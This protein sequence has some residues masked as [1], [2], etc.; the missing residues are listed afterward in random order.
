VSVNNCN[1]TSTILSKVDK[2]L[3]GVACP[4]NNNFII[5]SYIDYLGC[6]DVSII[7]CEKDS[8]PCVNDPVI[9]NCNMNVTGISFTQINDGTSDIIFH[10]ALGDIYGAKL[11]LSYLWTYDQNKFDLVGN[12]TDVAISL[13]LKPGKLLTSLTVPISVAITDADGCHD[14]KQCFYTPNGMKCNSSFVPCYSS[15]N[16]LVNYLYVNC[17]RAKTL[18]VR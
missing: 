3:W 15:S 9:L 4:V 11:P 17:A 7:P 10:I 18:T 8:V 5:E 14:T 16:F 1:I 13:K 12:V 6:E 2:L